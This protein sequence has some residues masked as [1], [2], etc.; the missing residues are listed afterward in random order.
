MSDFSDRLAELMRGAAGDSTGP[1][2]VTAAEQ[3]AA[4]TP[5]VE[6]LPAGVAPAVPPPPAAPVAAPP[7]Q[8]ASTPGGSHREPPRTTLPPEPTPS[9]A[10]TSTPV[11]RGP[12][13]G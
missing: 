5:A 9:R 12:S 7:A 8:V 3:S 10:V 4:D 2:Q 6:T 1:D 11:K 13:K